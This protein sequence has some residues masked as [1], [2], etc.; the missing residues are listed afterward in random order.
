[1]G[2]SEIKWCSDYL[3]FTLWF[4]GNV[5]TLKSAGWQL[6]TRYVVIISLFILVKFWYHTHTHARA[7]ERI[8]KMHNACPHELIVI[9]IDPGSAANQTSALSICCIIL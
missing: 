4:N 2:R 9:G 8:T 7:C 5:I 1:M 6:C 3:N